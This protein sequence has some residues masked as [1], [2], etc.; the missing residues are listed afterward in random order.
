[1]RKSH[2]KY[3]VCPECRVALKLLRTDKESDD[4]IEAGALGCEKCTAEF[5]IVA[6][7]PR[8]VPLENYASGFG[9]QWNEHSRTQYDSY[10]GA[11]ISETRFFEETG[12]PRKLEGE[13]IIEAGSGS[14]RFT[15]QAATTG[16]MVLSLDYSFAVDANYISNGDKENVL[17]VQGDIYKMPFAE[18]SAERVFCFGVLQHTPDPQKSL[19]QLPRYAKSGGSVVADN[20]IMP[21]GIRRLLATKYWIRPITKRFHPPTLYRICKLYVGIM[22][23]I[24]RV[25]HFCLPDRLSKYINWRLLLSDHRGEFDI[26]EKIMCEWAILDMMD[27]LGPAYDFPQHPETIQ[28][29]FEEAGLKD[30]DVRPGYNGVQGK[31][32]KP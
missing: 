29:W 25:I 31:G 10:S 3:L 12:W 30:I 15:E 11:N 21:K 8:F 32:T 17:I 1:M 13:T 22:W 27:K 6:H 24:S 5:P 9:L 2:L 23:P 18:N 7:V 16:A 19:N 28:R 20:Y 26:S 4:K 14:G